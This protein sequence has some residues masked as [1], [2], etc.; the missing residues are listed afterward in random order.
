MFQIQCKCGHSDGFDAFCRTEISGEL[1]PGQFQCPACGYAWA[2]RP[3]GP[4]TVSC[5]GMFVIPADRELVAVQ[6]RL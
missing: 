3:K 1:P 6:G 2:V 4:P 5:D